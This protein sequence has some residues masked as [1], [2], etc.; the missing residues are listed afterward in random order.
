[1]L[2]QNIRVVKIK[3][4]ESNKFFLVTNDFDWAN[5]KGCK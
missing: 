1:M 3:N 5:F 4:N 2:K